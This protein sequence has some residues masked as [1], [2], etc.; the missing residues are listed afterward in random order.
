MKLFAFLTI[1]LTFGA[2]AVLVGYLFEAIVMFSNKQRRNEFI[3]RRRTPGPPTPGVN[4]SAD[5]GAG[6]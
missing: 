5:G 3:S 4:G 1:G 6:E 2:A